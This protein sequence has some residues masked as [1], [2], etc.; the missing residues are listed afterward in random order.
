MTSDREALARA[1]KSGL[2]ADAAEA[3]GINSSVAARLDQDG[4]DAL[5]ALAGCRAPSEETWTLVVA[6]LLMRENPPTDPFAGLP[7]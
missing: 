6:R 3:R 2:I 4:R 5:A 1:R 7:T